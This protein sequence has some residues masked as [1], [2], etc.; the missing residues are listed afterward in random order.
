MTNTNTNELRAKV[1]GILNSEL[2]VVEVAQYAAGNKN[3]VT[4][5]M[6]E[7]FMQLIDRHTAEARSKL[8]DEFARASLTYKKHAQARIKKAVVKEL[9][10]IH[11][12]PKNR[13]KTDVY[14]MQ[15]FVHKR[16]KELEGRDGS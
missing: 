13:F 2:S 15:A 3:A 12:Y 4:Q 16:I 5:I 14:D 1:Q 7:E 11:D 9:Q 6:V 10:K 8:A